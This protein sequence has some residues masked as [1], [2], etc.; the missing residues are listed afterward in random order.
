MPLGQFPRLKIVGFLIIFCIKIVGFW[1]ER[2]YYAPY[3][4][5]IEVSLSRKLLIKINVLF[6]FSKSQNIQLGA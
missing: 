1:G 4:A 3:S 2:V 5:I 6:L